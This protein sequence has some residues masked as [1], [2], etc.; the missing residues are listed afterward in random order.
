MR[1]DVYVAV[2][3]SDKMC[4][5]SIG[6]CDGWVTII[7]QIFWLQDLIIIDKSLLAFEWFNSMICTTN[8]WRDQTY[9]SHFMGSKGIIKN[10]PVAHQSQ[11]NLHAHAV[12][13]TPLGTWMSNSYANI[14]IKKGNRLTIILLYRF[15][16]KI[17]ILLDRYERKR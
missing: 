13:H 11:A 6:I 5:M 9:K 17:V 7:E 2:I 3:L 4:A 1:A 16:V 10:L 15:I 8:Q 12:W 14:R